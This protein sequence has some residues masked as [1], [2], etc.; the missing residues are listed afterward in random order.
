MPR[1]TLIGYR[2]TGKSTVAALLGDIL[3]CG[4][5]DADLVLEGKLGRSIASLVRERGEPV[6]RD[7]EAVVLAD[8]LRCFPGVLSTGG[9]AVLRAENR[10]MLRQLGSPVVWLTAP[11]DVVRQRLAADPTTAERRPALAAPPSGRPSAPGDPLAEVTAA[12][13]DREPLY[14]SCAQYQ[15]DT[16]IASPAAV[17]AQIAAWLRT[18]WPMQAGNT[19]RGEGHPDEGRSG[20]AS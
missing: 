19:A 8:L 3:G 11:A 4:W 10:Q 12:L 15:V 2:G 7:E 9:G 5:C 1:I 13:A 18:E 17:A 14:R 16:S 20:A 6:F